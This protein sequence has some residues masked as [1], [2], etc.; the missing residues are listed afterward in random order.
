[1]FVVTVTFQIKPDQTE[2]FLP[3]MKQNAKASLDNEPGCVQFDVCVDEAAGNRIFLYELYVDRAAFDV[4]LASD[5]FVEF[6][7]AVASMIETK[8]VQT[9]TRISP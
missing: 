9:F 5:H 1:M 3:L 8:Q 6:D 7:Q 2:R 4:H